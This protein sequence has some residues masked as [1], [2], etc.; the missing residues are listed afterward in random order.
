MKK[1]KDIECNY[2]MKYKYKAIY[3]YYY[4]TFTGDLLVS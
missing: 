1:F 3:I 4:F 2:L